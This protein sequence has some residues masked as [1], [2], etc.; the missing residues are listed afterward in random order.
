MKICKLCEEQSKK[1]HN[2]NPHENLIKTDEIRIFKGQP[3]RFYEEQDY[4]CLTCKSKFT[5]STNK[6][7]MEWTL[8][9][10]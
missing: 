4:Q 6:N 7:D 9:R 3:P 5:H 1:S 10:G 2:G 8:W